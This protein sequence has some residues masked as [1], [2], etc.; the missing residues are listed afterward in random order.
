[1]QKLNIGIAEE[2]ARHNGRVIRLCRKLLLWNATCA[3][4]A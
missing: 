1:M 3:E 2:P 4:R